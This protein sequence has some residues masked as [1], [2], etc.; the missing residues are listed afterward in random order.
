MIKENQ[1]II[2]NKFFT[3]DDNN[4]GFKF[5][6]EYTAMNEDEESSDDPK[7]KERAKKAKVSFGK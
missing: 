4:M 5:K 3:R 2:L 7:A 6:V 1:T